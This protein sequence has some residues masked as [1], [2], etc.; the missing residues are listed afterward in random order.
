MEKVQIMDRMNNIPIITLE[1]ESI[2][3]SILKCLDESCLN[4]EKDIKEEVERVCNSSSL[5]NTI[6]KTVEIK[7]TN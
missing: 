2:K 1:V 4:M 6:A 7:K 5:K 3:R